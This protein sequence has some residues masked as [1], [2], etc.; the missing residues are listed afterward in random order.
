[1][2]DVTNLG[3]Q[4]PS[5]SASAAA[6][7]PRLHYT[8]KEPAT[9]VWGASMYAQCCYRTPCYTLVHVVYISAFYPY[10][11][12]ST[13]DQGY[14]ANRA[15]ADRCAHSITNDGSFQFQAFRR[16]RFHARHRSCA[17]QATNH[18]QPSST[19]ATRGTVK[20]VEHDN[21]NHISHLKLEG[22]RHRPAIAS[23]PSVALMQS[24]PW[25]I[26]AR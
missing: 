16:V 19:R 11:K 8:W 23:S 1:M 7:E 15:G 25:I 22:E 20:H 17:S 13:Q 4:G 14:A 12:A 18:E 10:A 5:L 21:I 6:T 26:S 24:N 3:Y 2:R 9:I